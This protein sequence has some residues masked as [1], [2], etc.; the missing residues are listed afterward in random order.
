MIDIETS[1]TLNNEQYSA[2]VA[3]ARQGAKSPDQA[4][5]LNTFL[6]EIERS[7][8]IKRFL[9]MVQW[10]EQDQ[11]LPPTARFPEAW[12]PSMRA[13]IELFERPVARTD[14]DA[15]LRQRASQPTN[16]LV[17]TDPGGLVGWQAIDDYF[18]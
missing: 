17:T 13:T 10:Q 7:N 11:P 3:L 9:L 15:L 5:V 16:I 1:V 2:L 12:P 8:N 6:L 14:V 4:R 18:G